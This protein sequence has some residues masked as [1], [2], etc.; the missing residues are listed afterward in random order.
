LQGDRIAGL[1]NWRALL[2]LAGLFLH[3]T[4][5]QEAHVALFDLIARIS[6]NFRMG[7]FFAVAGLLSLYAIRKHGADAWLARRL[8]QIGFP[9]A[10][11]LLVL[12]PFM[13]LCLSWHWYG[14]MVPPL[15]ALGWWH[16]WFL[17][18][19]LLFAPITW[20][21]Y[22][23]DK[24]E[25]LFARI[26]AWVEA[27][28]PS[29]TLTVLAVG[30]AAAVPVL[31]I[32]R[33]AAS[34]GPYQNA[35][36][37]L[38]QVASYAPLYLFGLILA[39]SP[40]LLRRVTART[41]PALNVLGLVFTTCLATRLLPGGSDW[42]FA[43]PM[44]PLNILTAAL[45]PPA[46]TVLVLRSAL[47]IRTTPPFFRQVADAAFTIYMLHFPMILVIDMLLDPLQLDPY[48]LYALTVGLSGWLSYLAHRLIV[49]RSP[50]LALLLNGANPGKARPVAIS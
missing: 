17:V 15:T 16:F 45:C 31:L 28:R 36:W 2:M 44:S 13:S 33:I 11:G 38:H 10:F 30:T 26:D 50:L 24:R 14:S 19:L 5:V 23:I 29:V 48:L 27:K 46:V 42:L 41:G 43:T 18:D 34:A 47:R 6:A 20:W 49:R 35:V 7:A 4:M 37:T 39:G 32:A 21:L 40:A 1:D 22:R 25:G 3:A 9:T 8:F 12:A